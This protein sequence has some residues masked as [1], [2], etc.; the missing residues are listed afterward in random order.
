MN[1]HLR[2]PQSNLRQELDDL[3]AHEVFAS[4]FFAE[5]QTLEL[6]ADLA[7]A[8]VGLDVLVLC[9]DLAFAT[10]ASET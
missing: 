2:S 6:V 4:S 10:L 7:V 8:F 5:D 9:M 1:T 3:A